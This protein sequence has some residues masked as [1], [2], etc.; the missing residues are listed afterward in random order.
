MIK[1]DKSLKYEESVEYR[2]YVH[3]TND[4]CIRMSV[5]AD[6]Y[7]GLILREFCSLSGVTMDCI[8]QIKGISSNGEE[9]NCAKCKNIYDMITIGEIFPYR[10]L[11]DDFVL[12][13]TYKP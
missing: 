12:H 7:F 10:M 5:T 9:F 1:N 13:I 2:I 3:D 8:I 4:I 11:H 6:T